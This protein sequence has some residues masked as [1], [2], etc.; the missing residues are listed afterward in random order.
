MHMTDEFKVYTD[1]APTFGITKHNKLCA[2]TFNRDGTVVNI[3]SLFYFPLTNILYFFHLYL[4]QNAA[5]VGSTGPESSVRC[6]RQDN[7][8]GTIS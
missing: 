4:I 1:T 6:Y 8:N 7:R 3:N 5:M 2:F